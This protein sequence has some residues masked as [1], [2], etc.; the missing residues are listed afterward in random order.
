MKNKPIKTKDLISNLNGYL[1]KLN[2]PE[3][4]EAV[5]GTL[6]H[7][8]K[9]GYY[10]PCAE[11]LDR[12]YLSLKNNEP[13]YSVYEGLEYVAEALN[14]YILYSKGYIRNLL[15]LNLDDVKTIADLGCGIGYSTALLA[16]LFP[17]SKV[18]GTQLPGLQRD[19]AEMKG[20]DCGFTIEG[21]LSNYVDLVFASDYL[22]H[23][24]NPTD[25][26]LSFLQYKPKYLVLANSFAPTSTGHFDS[27]IIDGVGVD[28]KQAG[29]KFNNWLR[30][31]GYAKLETGFYNGRPSVWKISH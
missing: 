19:I 14:C 25:H 20:A 28:D 22:E 12:W 13:D 3:I 26:A 4:T 23:F 2:Q 18:I 9:K 16:E 15:R 27:Y 10:A 7:Y 17:G 1:H 24:P 5:Q 11:L 6:K 30:K 8:T 31:Q 21:S 29:R